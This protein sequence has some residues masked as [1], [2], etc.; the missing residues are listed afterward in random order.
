MEE[1]LVG[2]AKTGS[3][4]P[5]KE[6]ETFVAE[7]GSRR[8]PGGGVI[9]TRE[10]PAAYITYEV[11]VYGLSLHWGRSRSTLHGVRYDPHWL[12][13]ARPVKMSC[14]VAVD[15]FPT[16]TPS[17]W[18]WAPGFF[19]WGGH[20]REPTLPGE[21]VRSVEPAH[22]H[23]CPRECGYCCGFVP[24]HRVASVDPMRALLNE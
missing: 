8:K 23:L 11:A 6:A 22:C 5:A 12:F 24:A 20:D 15:L 4:R 14:G 1:R 2:F 7:F 10:F 17:D 19:H 13:T 16:Q 3:G 18:C 21:V 9:A